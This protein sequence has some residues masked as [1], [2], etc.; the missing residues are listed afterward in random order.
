MALCQAQEKELAPV[1]RISF[2]MFMK[3]C[4]DLLADAGVDLAGA[5]GQLCVMTWLEAYKGDMQKP[6]SDK[7]RQRWDICASPGR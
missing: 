1:G 2:V 7:T 6:P 3:P 4:E 5:V